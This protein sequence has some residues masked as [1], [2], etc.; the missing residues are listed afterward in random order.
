MALIES[1]KNAGVPL[2][3]VLRVSM[4][5]SKM[6]PAVIET[7]KSIHWPSARRRAHGSAAVGG[8]GAG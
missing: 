2:E 6:A 4:P 1:W 3:A 7:R 8:F 5:R